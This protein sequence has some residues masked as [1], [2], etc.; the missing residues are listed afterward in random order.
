MAHLD[1]GPQKLAERGGSYMFLVLEGRRESS[2]SQELRGPT[3]AGLRPPA[4]NHLFCL[5]RFENKGDPK[6]EEKNTKRGD[7]SEEA[8]T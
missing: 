3:Y 1:P 4:K 2:G 8:T 5:V 7:H 6:K